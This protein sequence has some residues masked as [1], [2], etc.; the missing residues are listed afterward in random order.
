MFT[1][2]VIV[3]KDGKAEG[4]IKIKGDIIT[5]CNMQSWS[6][7]RTGEKNCNKGPFWI[8]Q[9]NWNADNRLN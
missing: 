3:M 9:Q 4:L 8:S 6:E 7:S 5:K 2:N 1:K